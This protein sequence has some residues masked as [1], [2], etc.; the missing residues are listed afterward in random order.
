MNQYYK[1]IYFLRNSLK[2]APLLNT[3]TQGTD[4]IDNVKKN[5]FPLAHINIQSSTVQDGQVLFVFEIAV[6]DIRNVSKSQPTDKFI[7]NTNEIDNL[8]T[9]HGILNYFVTK[10]KM[11]RNNDDIEVEEVAQLEP[12]LM[13][14]TN[15]LDGWKT[16]VTLSIPNNEISVCCE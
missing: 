14:F 6:V 9:T 16:T 4:I 13:E 5:I 10:M 7:S 12:I 1:C 3:I 11:K 8:N 2:D 15:M